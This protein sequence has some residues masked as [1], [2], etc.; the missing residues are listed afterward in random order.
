MLLWCCMVFSDH[1]ALV[2]AR[3][4]PSVMDA[5]TRPISPSAFSHPDFA[6]RCRLAYDEKIK[7]CADPS[8]LKRLALLK[9]AMWEV[10]HGLVRAILDHSIIQLPRKLRMN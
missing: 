4:L 1:R 8:R 5:S 2:V 9:D 6:P 3:R 7:E 10:A